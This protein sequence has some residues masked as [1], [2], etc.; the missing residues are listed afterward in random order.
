MNKNILLDCGA[1]IGQGFDRLLKQYPFLNVPN[2]IVH[3]FEP[4]PDAYIILKTKYPNAIIHQCAVW[5]KDTER[6]L[7]IENVTLAGQSGA[8]GHTTNILQED[9]KIPAH[10]KP[11][12]MSEWP[13]KVSVIIKCINLSKFIQENFDKTDI[14]TLKLDVEGSEFEVL[15]A[16]IKDGTLSYINYLNIEWHSH[17]RKTNPSNTKYIEEFA[18]YNITMLNPKIN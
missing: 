5:N 12:W 14:I 16:M 6:I 11:E 1:N 2:L 18:K 17:M 7:N 10:T 13:P 15:D 3:M 9:F 4:L 8:L